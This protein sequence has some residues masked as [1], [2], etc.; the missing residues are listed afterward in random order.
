LRSSQNPQ[1]IIEMHDVLIVGAR[2]AGAALALGL[3]RAG[4][5]VRI[6]DRARFPS[7]TM[8]GHYIHPAGVAALRRLGLYE[9]LVATGA[10]AQRRITVDFG[11][12]ALSGTPAPAPDG[13]TEAFAPRRHVF[14]TMLAAAA[15][16]AGAELWEGTSLIAPLV[17]D[18]RVT[19]A[20]VARPGGGEETIRARL[21]VGADG[22]RS[23]LARAVGAEAYSVSP[24]TACTY[25][26]YWSGF[27]AGETRLF[28]RP[29][30]FLVV[31]PTND[32]MTFLAVAWPHSAFHAVRADI[33]GA[34]RA[35]AAE[36]PWIAER[37][38]GARQEER[39]VGTGDLDGFLRVPH[40][41]GWALVGDAG[42][43]KDPITAQGMT[44]ALLH[45]EMLAEAVVAGLSGAMPLDAAL[46]G[47]R[48]RRDE[49]AGPMYALTCDL[50]RLAP[51]TPE[52][53]GLVTA[54]AGN[55][56]ETRRF[57]GIMA[58]TV[59]IPEFFAPG[60]L[61]R[62]VGPARAA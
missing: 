62:I 1:E 28:V 7:D 11:P 32:G 13:T 59:A 58:G 49:L 9:R 38:A 22:K 29:G 50:A 4:L 46:E 61:A 26:A 40:G 5:K 34:Y 18:G 35:A 10:P 15:V 14:D 25:Y 45:A 53:A 47:Y 41:P 3:A 43:H 51:P 54:L 6:I 16:E 33:A 31:A 20:R 60:N 36:V 12:V 23:R 21:V 30:R 57:L 52:M 24:A 2:C 19:G 39:F 42:Y 55:P 8:S 44:D 17:E 27:A 48:R 56:E 37:L